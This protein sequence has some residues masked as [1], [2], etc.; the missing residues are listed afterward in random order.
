MLCVH[1]P[2]CEQIA[3]QHREIRMF[4]FLQATPD[5]EVEESDLDEVE[6][7][8]QLAGSLSAGFCIFLLRLQASSSTKAMEVKLKP[9][10]H[11]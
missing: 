11:G 1:G 2:G 7:E 3:L 4:C 9:K 8:A 5:F 10:A 6:V